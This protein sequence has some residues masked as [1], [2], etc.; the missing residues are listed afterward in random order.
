MKL[1]KIAESIITKD[2]GASLH[3]RTTEFSNYHHPLLQ[4][5]Q[6]TISPLRA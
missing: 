5:I 3:K 6:F 1:A 4:T 2:S